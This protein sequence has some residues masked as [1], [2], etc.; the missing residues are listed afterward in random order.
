MSRKRKASAY[1]FDIYHWNCGSW[2]RGSEIDPGSRLGVLGRPELIPGLL[3]GIPL[4]V[5][6]P[7]VLDR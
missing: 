5:T 7:S 3:A 1:T 2:S 4:V 6:L